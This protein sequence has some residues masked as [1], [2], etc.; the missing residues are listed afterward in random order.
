[1]PQISGFATKS[2]RYNFGSV[3][4]NIS[5]KTLDVFGSFSSISLEIR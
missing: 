5:P 3:F 4:C 2:K 1:M